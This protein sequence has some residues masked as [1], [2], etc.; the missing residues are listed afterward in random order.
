MSQPQQFQVKLVERNVV[1][2][3]VDFNKLT[4][5]IQQGRVAAHDCVRP[6]GTTDWRLVK[7]VPQFAVYL[8]HADAVSVDDEAEAFEA[9]ELGFG[10]SHHGEEEEDP[11]MIPLIDI[12]LVLLVFFMLT[13]AEMIAASPVETPPA[14]NARVISESAPLNVNVAFVDSQPQ[15]FL[16]GGDER[17]YSRAELDEFLNHVAERIPPGGVETTIVRAQAQVPYEAIQVLTAG[18]TSKGLDHIEAGVSDHSGKE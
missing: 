11:D 5:W 9:V 13:A 18:L 2:A 4:D 7:D 8:P 1:S 6:A 15:F 14:T 17:H 10:G 16:D 3:P 12:S